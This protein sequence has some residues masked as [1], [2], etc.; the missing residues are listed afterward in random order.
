MR[1]TVF[2]TPI[3]NTAEVARII[4]RIAG[5]D[6]AVSNDSA[7]FGEVVG[8]TQEVAQKLKAQLIAADVPDVS[9]EPD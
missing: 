3:I 1:F 4:Q 2:F 8:L 9:I 7:H 5:L 6:M